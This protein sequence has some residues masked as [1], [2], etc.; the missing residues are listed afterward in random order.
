MQINKKKVLSINCGSFLEMR[1]TPIRIKSIINELSKER[2]LILHTSSIDILKPFNFPHVPLGVSRIKNICRISNYIKTNEIDVIIFHTVT[3]SR[4]FIPLFFLNRRCKFI[5]EMHGFPEEESKLHSNS[6]NL[7]YYK[8]KIISSLV[9]ILSDFVTT[10]S[11]TATLKIKKYNSNISTIYGGV[12]LHK[13]NPELKNNHDSSRSEIIIGYSG[14]GRVWQGLDFLFQAYLQ[15]YEINPSYKLHLLLSDDIDIPVHPGI[16]VYKTAAHEAVA[17]FNANCDILVIPRIDNAVNT[18]SFPSKLMEY[19]AMGVPVVASRTSDIHRIIKHEFTGMLYD[20]GNVED[21]LV[22]LLK[23][24]NFDLRSKLGRNAFL[25]VRR[26]YTWEIQ[27]SKFT[28][29]V[30]SV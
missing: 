29:I 4:Y 7:K 15:L 12:D 6:T 8:S 30:K 18:L 11:E 21:L 2:S 16:K 27:G 22:N 19:L 23:L 13:F 24:E 14:N 28:N 5:L 25:E 10:C 3:S 26:S 9:Y 1:G 20:P 17:M